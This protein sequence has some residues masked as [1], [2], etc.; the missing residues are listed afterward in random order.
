VRSVDAL[1]AVCD[2]R[3]LFGPEHG[4]D[5]VAAAGQHIASG[6][7]RRSGLPVVSLYG[8]HQAPAAEELAQIDVL[9]CD[10]QDVGVRYYTYAWT[11]LLALEAAGKVGLPMWVLDR[12]NPLGG[13]AV[14]GSLLRDGYR[15]L[16]GRW[17]VPVRHGLTLGELALLCNEQGA[18]GVDLEVVQMHGWRREQRHAATGLPWVAPSPNMPDFQTA[19]LYGGNCLVEGTTL[20][21]GRGTALPFQ[22]VGAPWIDGHA[23]AD[24]LNRRGLTGVAARATAFAPTTSKYAGQRC[25]GVQL[26]ITDEESL[27]PVA[28]GV[29]LLATVKELCP[30][31]FAWVAPGAG[32]TY[33]IDLLWGSDSLRQTIDASA[34]IAPLLEQA[35]AEA[36]AFDRER[37]TYLRYT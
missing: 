27:R 28:L 33:S 3:L 31:D 32:E 12:P 13:L 37:Q 20:S 2:L 9:L 17:A 16:V 25:E 5:G 36:Q 10:L 24:A 21:E 6:L 30:H 7:D 29:A 23:L 34:A 14:E 26:H 35:D 4:L 8:A 11:L 1:R 19:L 18:L 15:S 22:Q